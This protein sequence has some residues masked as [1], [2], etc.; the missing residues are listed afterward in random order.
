MI[1]RKPYPPKGMR[2]AMISIADWSGEG[3]LLAVIATIAFSVIAYAMLSKGDSLIL[4]DLKM[5]HES[6]GQEKKISGDYGAITV[7]DNGFNTIQKRLINKQYFNIVGSSGSFKLQSKEQSIT[8]LPFQQDSTNPIQYSILIDCTE[9]ATK[10]G[11]DA[12]GIENFEDK[13]IAKMR[14]Y[15]TLNNV[16][17]NDTGTV[18]S[19]SLGTDN[20]CLFAVMNL[21]N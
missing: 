2:K 1:R 5:L 3:I 16:D 11:W 10:R 19:V 21:S 15:T 14:Q 8:Y 13:T 18:N 20:E 12:L 6:L 7:D 17:T 9:E 4:E